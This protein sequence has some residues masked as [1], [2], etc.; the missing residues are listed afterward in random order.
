MPAC[1]RPWNT[2][3]DEEACLFPEH[4]LKKLPSQSH[5]EGMY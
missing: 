2:E 5:G 4:A 3:M 1:A